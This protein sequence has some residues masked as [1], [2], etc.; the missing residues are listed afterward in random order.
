MGVEA[1]VGNNGDDRND[2][3][4]CG[5]MPNSPAWRSSNYVFE[6]PGGQVRGRYA[7]LQTRSD[8]TRD[9]MEVGQMIVAGLTLEPMSMTHGELRLVH[10][11][12]MKVPGVDWFVRWLLVFVLAF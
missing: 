11:L 3:T 1:V 6:C 8:S 9:Y 2:N 5:Q 10:L 7:F 12:I 4:L